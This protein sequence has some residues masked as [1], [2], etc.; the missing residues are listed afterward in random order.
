MGR[1]PHAWSRGLLCTLVVLSATALPRAAEGGGK[2]VIAIAGFFDETGSPVWDVVKAIQPKT[3][4]YLNQIGM[5]QH[6]SAEDIAAFN[7]ARE[8]VQLSSGSQRLE[9][10]EKIAAKGIDKFVYL[11]LVQEL[12]AWGMVDALYALVIDVQTREFSAVPLGTYNNKAAKGQGLTRD[13]IIRKTKIAKKADAAAKQA[14]GILSVYLTTESRAARDMVFELE[15]TRGA[16]KRASYGKAVALVL[17]GS[18]MLSALEVVGY[19]L[20]DPDKADDDYLAGSM[21]I[22]GIAYSLPIA[23]GFGNFGKRIGLGIHYSK[24]Q[25]QFKAAAGTTY[26]LPDVP[27]Q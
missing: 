27:R 4:E 17:T 9:D 11:Q 25:R 7:S 3:A 15:D 10:L 14:A 1:T 22:M 16:M 23:I 26:R 5:V 12:S 20:D 24:L 19:F 8:L 2:P 21:Q 6:Q 18:A 13:K